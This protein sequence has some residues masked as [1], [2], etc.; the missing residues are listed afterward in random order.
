MF[1][2]MYV[3][4]YVCK[5]LGSTKNHQSSVFLTKLLFLLIGDMNRLFLHH[6]MKPKVNM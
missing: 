1:V 3:C 6:F 5:N 4:M 2:C